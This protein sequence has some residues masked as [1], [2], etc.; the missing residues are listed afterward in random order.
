MHRYSEGARNLLMQ[1]DAKT[2]LY[3]AMYQDGSYTGAISFVVCKEKRYWSEKNRRQLGEV[4]KL[5][6]I[7]MAKNP[8]MNALTR[9]GIQPAGIRFP[10]RPHFLFPF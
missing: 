6:S 2:V 7:H 10:H 8:S 1:G 5:I 9:G 4:T 3:A